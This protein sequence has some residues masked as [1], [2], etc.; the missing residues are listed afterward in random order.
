MMQLEVLTAV[1][2]IDGIHRLAASLRPAVD[3]VSY[4]VNIQGV[5]PGTVLP[6]E[7][8]RPDM[9]VRFTDSIGVSRNR[10][11]LLDR[12]TAPLVLMSDDDLDY[13]ADG[14]RGVIEAFQNYPEADLLTFRH[15]G[16]DPTFV[17]F[18]ARSFDLRE[19]PKDYFVTCFDIAIRRNEATKELRFD[20]RFSIGTPFPQGEEDIFM[21]DARR[22]KLRARYVPL[23][24]SHHPGATTFP[25]L[26]ATKDYISGKG[27][28][29]ARTRPYTW[30]LRMLTH[31]LRECKNPDMPAVTKYV[32]WWTRG[33][34]Q[35]IWMMLLTPRNKSRN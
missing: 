13:T 24:V 8:V 23:T 14:L 21:A 6:D 35:A 17:R 15:S 34:F 10:N 22:M 11:E 33:A 20:D 7:L 32:A 18:P 2:G 28:V 3:G 16:D 5:Y 27:A 25:R 19:T 30:P 29:F 9:R 12:A 1:Y 4:L 26:R 31:A